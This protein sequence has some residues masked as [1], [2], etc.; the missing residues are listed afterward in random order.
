[1]SPPLITIR[2]TLP[3]WCHFGTHPSSDSDRSRQFTGISGLV[4]RID[5][6]L[7]CVSRE[8]H[9]GMVT[10][11][12]ALR[13]KLCVPMTVDAEGFYDWPTEAEQIEFLKRQA[14][15]LLDIFG[16][17]RDGRVLSDQEVLQRANGVRM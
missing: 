4:S 3:L 17:A 13:D 6:D 1:L 16:D 15:G 11:Q 8:D 5:R 9:N 2:K 12:L 10:I 7:E 14:Q